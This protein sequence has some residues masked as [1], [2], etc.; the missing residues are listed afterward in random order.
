MTISKYNTCSIKFY[1][2]IKKSRVVTYITIE[3]SEEDAEQGKE[4]INPLKS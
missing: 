4:K 3:T 2:F 1:S